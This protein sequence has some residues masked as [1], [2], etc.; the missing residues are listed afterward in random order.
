MKRLVGAL[1][2]DWNAARWC[3]APGR[4]FEGHSAPETENGQSL[5]ICPSTPYDMLE[6]LRNA[7]AI[8]EHSARTVVILVVTCGIASERLCLKPE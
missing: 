2:N 7:S 6:R 5:R 3:R 4:G 1:K 8:N